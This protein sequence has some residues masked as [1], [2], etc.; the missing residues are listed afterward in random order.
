[1]TAE[2]AAAQPQSA[3]S[4][5]RAFVEDKTAR[6]VPAASGSTLALFGAVETSVAAAQ[7]VSG[8]TA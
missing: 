1:M 4:R 7:F 3:N 8:S 6:P 5:Q 2:E